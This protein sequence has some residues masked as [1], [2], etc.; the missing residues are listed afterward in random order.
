V[1]YEDYHLPSALLREKKPEKQEEIPDTT[2]IYEWSSTEKKFK[3][4]TN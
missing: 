3:K 2:T 4:R 1:C